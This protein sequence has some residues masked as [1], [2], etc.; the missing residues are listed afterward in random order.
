[1]GEA[2]G[3]DQEAVSVSSSQTQGASGAR[4]WKPEVGSPKEGPALQSYGRASVIASQASCSSPRSSEVIPVFSDQQLQLQCW[5][6]HCTE[7]GPRS[8]IFF[9]IWNLECGTDCL[10]IWW[11]AIL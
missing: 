9:I 6:S 7:D 10:C 8:I 3:P 5:D 2:L 1:M 11:P 4:K